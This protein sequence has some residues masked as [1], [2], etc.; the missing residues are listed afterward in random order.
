MPKLESNFEGVRIYVAEI[1]ATMH[2][3]KQSYSTNFI[4]NSAG[5]LLISS[6]V[7][8]KLPSVLQKPLMTKVDSNYPTLTQIFDNISNVITVLT[9]PNIN[10]KLRSD[11]RTMHSPVFKPHKPNTSSS[12][13]ETFATSLAGKT[14]KI[15]CKFCD[16]NGYFSCNCTAY[17]TLEQRKTRCSEL[18]RCFKCL[19]STHMAT[20][21]SGNR[22]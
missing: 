5:Y 12:T 16:S 21:C 14:N 1:K 20:Q 3:L 15:Y 13:L 22:G 11:S 10:N 4:V 17:K 19:S 6:V 9:K 7:F 18:R 2:D 8:H